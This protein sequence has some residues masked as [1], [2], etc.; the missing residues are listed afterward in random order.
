MSRPDGISGR[1]GYAKILD[2]WERPVKAGEPVGCVATSFTFVP[3]FFETEC[4]GRFLGLE[5]APED[6]SVYYVEREEKLAQLACAA[7]LV[8]QHHVRGSRNLR[9]DLLSARLPRGILHAKISLLIW[10]QQARLI[11]SSANLTPDGCRRNHEV[12]GVL[13][14]FPGSDAPL[15]VLWEIL[16][17]LKDAGGYATTPTADAGP[18]IQRWLRFLERVRKATRH[19]GSTQPRA[20]FTKTQIVTVLSGPKRPSVLQSL[21]AF[22]P[23]AAGPSRAYVI[24]P[25]FDPPNVP[26]KPARNLWRLLT[27]RGDKSV[28]YEVVAEEVDE[29]GRGQLLLHAPVTLQKE[30]PKEADCAVSFQALELDANRPLHAKCLWLENRN[31]SIYLM[32]SSN[33]TSAGLGLGLVTNLEA[34][35]VYII[36]QGRNAKGRRALT[37]GWLTSN[38]ITRDFRLEQEPPDEQGQDA[39]AEDAILL[40]RAFGD[41]TF[42]V[43]SKQYF[44]SLSIHGSPPGGWVV[45]HESKDDQIVYTEKEWIHSGRRSV[46]LIPWKDARPPSALRVRWNDS[47]GWAWWPVNVVDASALPPPDELRQL[48]LD[49]LVAIL[50]SASPL[51]Q[52][53]ARLLQRHSNHNSP[54]K[55]VLDPHR[56]VDTSQFLIPRTRRVTWALTNLRQ[57]L[58]LP[59]VSV[60]TLHW[61]LHGPVGVMKFAEAINREAKTPQERCFLLTELALELA[62]VVPQSAPHCLSRRE[63]KTGLR[64]AIRVLRVQALQAVPTGDPIRRYAGRAFTEANS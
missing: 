13:D 17:F 4:L 33:F 63:I 29:R 16:N 34:N 5:S 55:D 3:D 2:A 18:A 46:I 37:D 28:Q 11:V 21:K 45:L 35:L 7:A 25:F 32:G 61:R 53:I 27:A 26:N 51:H 48:T 10:S 60:E 39:P 36:H 50:T 12:F 49:E 15:P 14:F 31:W 43:D 41:A 57:R 58:E 38:P 64:A 24:S 19:W 1:A 30:C 59:A 54:D 23:E 20:R 8:D 52:A 9:W 47:L 56:R 62:R 44:L 40:P 22:W 42:G 6:C